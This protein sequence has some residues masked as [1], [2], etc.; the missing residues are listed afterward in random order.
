[1]MSHYLKILL[2]AISFNL[3]SDEFMGKPEGFLDLSKI[4]HVEMDDLN[5]K[6][7]E[8]DLFSLPERN[9]KIGREKAFPWN[10]FFL[11]SLA[12][13]T[14]I[15]L[16][17]F[18]REKKLSI[19]DI[20]AS[21]K[22]QNRLEA[23][24]LEELPPSEFYEKILYVLKIYMEERYQINAPVKTREEFINSLKNLEL[25]QKIPELALSELLKLAD[26][27]KFAR[28]AP[29]TK[30]CDDAYTMVENIIQQ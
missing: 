6:T 30:D 26:L 8:A 12:I 18:P 4:S 29:T 19:E 28:H 14:F 15:A 11:L 17:L 24:S 16:R 23:I 27:V 7:M 9:L 13:L 10:K 2:C 3:S 21:N 20:S 25:S 1:M 5:E 22:A